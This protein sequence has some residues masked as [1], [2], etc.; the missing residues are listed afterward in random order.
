MLGTHAMAIPQGA[1]WYFLATF[2]RMKAREVICERDSQPDMVQAMHLISGETLMR[3]TTA[4]GGN[5]DK[6]MADAS[7]TDEDVV[8]KLSLSTAVRETDHRQIQTTRR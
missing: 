7:L 6:W 1:Q 3:Q 4:K 8:R 5:L 2:G